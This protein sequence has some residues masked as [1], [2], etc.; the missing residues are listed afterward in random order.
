LTTLLVDT[1]VLIKWFHSEGE[2]EVEAA[3]AIRDANQRGEIE[4][5]GLRVTLVS[6]DAKLTEAGL[7]ESPTRVTER[8][9]LESPPQDVSEEES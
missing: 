7:A 5:R 8:L 2:A 3:R 1:S 9:R 6:A 4:A